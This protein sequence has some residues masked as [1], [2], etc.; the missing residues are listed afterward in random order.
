MK[1]CCGAKFCSVALLQSIYD[2]VAQQAYQRYKYRF[3]AVEY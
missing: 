2:D 1:G 3:A